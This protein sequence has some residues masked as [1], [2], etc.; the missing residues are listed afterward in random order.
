MEEEFSLGARHV[1]GKKRGA[2]DSSTFY[3]PLDRKSG[4]TAGVH[5]RGGRDRFAG[6]KGERVVVVGLRRGA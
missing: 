1:S 4:V 6:L 5:E 3:S 2:S